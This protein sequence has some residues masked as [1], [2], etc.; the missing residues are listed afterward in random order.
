MPSTRRCSRYL[1]KS[2]MCSFPVYAFLSHGIF[3]CH[4]VI[5]TVI[6]Y[7][8]CTHMPFCGLSRP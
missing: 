4:F 8:V 5:F 3:V 1:W 2:H 6:M 7:I